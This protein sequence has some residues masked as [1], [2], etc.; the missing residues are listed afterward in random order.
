[1][2]AM[3]W[4]GLKLLFTGIWLYFMRE[5]AGGRRVTELASELHGSFKAQPWWKRWLE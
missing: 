2:Q 4:R 3:L 1:M 5:R